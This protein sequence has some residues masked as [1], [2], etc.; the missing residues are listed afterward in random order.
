MRLMNGRIYSPG[1][2][3]FTSPDPF[4]QE[5]NNLQSYN[6]YS[7]VMNNPLTHTDPSGYW[8]HKQ[9]GYLRGVAAIAITVVTAG[10][11]SWASEAIIAGD[12][13]ATAEAGAAYAS[14]VVAGG[15][16][17]GYVQ[18]GNMKGAVL[19]GLEAGLDVGINAQVPYSGNAAG[20]VAAHAVSGGV[21]EVLRGG[22]F[23]NGFISAGLTAAISPHLVGNQ[24]ARGVEASI[25]GGSI[26]QLTGGK[27]AN[28]AVSAAFQQ[29][30]SAA[31][32]GGGGQGG[33]YADETYLQEASRF[34]ADSALAQ[35][36]P[37]S[38]LAPPPIEVLPF[39]ELT[40][41]EELPTGSAGGP[42][43]QKAFPRSMNDQPEGTPCTYCKTPTTR[44]PGPEQYNGDHIIPKVKGGNNT[45][46][47]HLDSCRTCNL[48]KGPR[49]PAEWY[50]FM[51][52]RTIK[53]A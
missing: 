22:K 38:L 24:F 36:F 3:R 14:I 51:M 4:V 27:F 25:L 53:E 37:L 6:R 29:S 48:N 33:I 21:L 41:L 11:A 42:G 39:E 2:M 5:P 7:Y 40:P 19:G 52:E 9:Q 47:N 44:E 15:A 20:N 46:E 31:I 49:T 8:G 50:K 26:S 16:A 12:A 1:T 17:A 32:D 28:G 45:P 43:A 34:N 18:T 30:F 13:S 35:F 23:G 10:T